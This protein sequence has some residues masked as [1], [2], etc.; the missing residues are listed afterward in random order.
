MVNTGP[1]F[2]AHLSLYS[3][4]LFNDPAA[5]PPNRS[6]SPSTS[7]AYTPPRRTPLPANVARRS[8]DDMENSTSARESD[9]FSTLEESS[10]NED[11]EVPPP[12]QSIPFLPLRKFRLS[13]RMRD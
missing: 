6:A 5:T 4:N 9:G 8:I 12:R 13:N 1:L 2:L 7:P 10:D 11:C 3:F